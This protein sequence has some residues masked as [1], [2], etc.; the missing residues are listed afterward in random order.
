MKNHRD[1]E[2]RVVNEE[3]V[4]FLPVLAQALAVIAGENDKW[5]LGNALI[6]QKAN[7]ASNLRVGKCNFS[8]IEAV[9]ILFAVRCGRAIR[10]VRIVQV[11]P[12]EKFL[13]VILGEPIQSG[14]GYYVTR[15]FHFIKIRFL[16]TVEIEMIVIEVKSAV[17][18]EAGI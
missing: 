9:F 6:F 16:Q 13:L 2:G 1:V 3:T 10:K 8:V 5:V 11:H 17:Q 4:S 15:A 18:A 12:E 7:Q 14:I